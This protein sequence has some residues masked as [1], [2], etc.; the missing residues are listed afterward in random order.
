MLSDARYHATLPVADL[1]RARRF[2]EDRLGLTP[3]VETPAG[4]FYVGAGDTRFLLFPTQGRPSGAHTQLGFAVADLA[5]EVAE[6]KSRGAVFEEYDLP[7]LKTV[8]GIAEV[9]EARAAWLKDSEGNLLGF[10]QLPG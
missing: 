3:A 1:E 2:Y 9:G 8:D 5:T 4:L 10:V 6:L 7:G